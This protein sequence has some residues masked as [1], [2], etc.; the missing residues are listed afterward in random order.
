MKAIC[1]RGS[2]AVLY[3]YLQRALHLLLDRFPSKEA[4]S[5]LDD[6]SLQ[7]RL[8]ETEAVI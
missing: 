6:K 5:L 8:L 3:E 4:L 1:V 2:L 7:T